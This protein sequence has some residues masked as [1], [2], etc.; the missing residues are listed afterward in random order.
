[1]INTFCV[2]YNELFSVPTLTAI[3]YTNTP[4]WM[5]FMMI[6]MNDDKIAYHKYTIYYTY[7]KHVIL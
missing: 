1:M 2:G 4:K 5:M 3:N 7:N 6:M